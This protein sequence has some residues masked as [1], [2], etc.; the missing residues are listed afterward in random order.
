MLHAGALW[1]LI[2]HINSLSPLIGLLEA[3]GMSLFNVTHEEMRFLSASSRLR[4]QLS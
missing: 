4:V 2:R 3:A 1:Y